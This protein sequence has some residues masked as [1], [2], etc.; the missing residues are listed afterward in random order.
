[1]TA[2]ALTLRLIFYETGDDPVP[3][4]DTLSAPVD[5]ERGRKVLAR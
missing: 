2:E 5:A 3:T 4:S 1:M